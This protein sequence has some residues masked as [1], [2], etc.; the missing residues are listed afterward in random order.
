MDIDEWVSQA[1][2]L[3]E[4]IE[5]SR[6]TAREIVAQH[7]KGR[8][9]RDQVT[10]ARSTVTRLQKGINFNNALLESLEA[11]RSIDGQ[12][13]DAKTA[14]GQ[15][16]LPQAIELLDAINQLIAK[17]QLPQNAYVLGILS[18]KA[19]DLRSDIAAAL[20]QKW[21]GVVQFDYEASK[22]TIAQH[23]PGKNNN[24]VFSAIQLR[25]PNDFFR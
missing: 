24:L 11:V 25:S 16:R 12:L 21:N 9:L 5:Q 3:H 19:T 14:V 6:V 15:D 8:T 1:N 2:Q 23:S 20:R 10:D 7:E 17:A 18:S 22:M 4:D 13:A